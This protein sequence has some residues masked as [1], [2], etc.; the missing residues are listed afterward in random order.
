MHRQTSLRSQERLA[1][2]VRKILDADATAVLPETKELRNLLLS[3]NKPDQAA[4]DRAL[5]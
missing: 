2:K 5:L 1:R 3:W 4:P